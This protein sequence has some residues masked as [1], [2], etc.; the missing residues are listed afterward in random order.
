MSNKV[1]HINKYKVL[2]YKVILILQKLLCIIIK[3]YK[4]YEKTKT[5]IKCSTTIGHN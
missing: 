4:T 5:I 1:I 3:K 2:D